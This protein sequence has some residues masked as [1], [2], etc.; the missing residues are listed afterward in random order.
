MALNITGAKY[1]IQALNA[2]GTTTATIATGTFV[3]G[4]FSLTSQR[5]AS[6]FTS[7]GVFKGIAWVRRFISTT[8]VELENQFVDPC[9]GLFATQLVGDQIL[10]SKNFSESAGIGFAVDATAL[11]VA[12]TGHITFGTLG[13]ETSVCVYDERYD[14]AS[15]DAF[16]PVGGVTVLG[17]LISYDGTG[18]ASL[19]WSRDCSIKPRS[20][21]A[22]GGAGSVA[23][24]V[25][26]T[27][28]TSAH[29]FM[30]G[31]GVSGTFQS[32]DF[33]GAQGSGATNKSFAFFGTRLNYP[34][35]SP[36]NGGS[37]ASNPS[38]HVLYKTIH[39][40]A[41]SNADLIM[42]GNGIA[43]PSFLSFTQSGAG[44][45]LGIFRA[46]SVANFGSPAGQRTIVNDLGTGALIDG[47]GGG[48]Y[49]FVNVITPAVSMTRRNS[50]IPIQLSF[51]DD[52]TNLQIGST[53]VVRRT[54]DNVVAASV[55]G[56]AS[57]TFTAS[58][59]QSTYSATVNGVLTPL[60]DFTSYDYG[61]KDYGYGV[62]SGNHTV[63]NYPLGTGGTGRNLSLGGLINQLSDADVTLSQSA[64]L[65]LSSKINI[66]AGTSTVSVTSGSVT[67]DELYD[68]AVAH[69]VSSVANAQVPSLSAYLFTRSGTSAAL[70]AGWSIAVDSGATL[71]KGTK[72]LGVTSN[73]ALTGTLTNI[74]ITGNV[75][76]ATPTNLTGVTVTGTLTYNTNSATSI[77]YTTCTIGT[78]AN[79]GVG[80]V[81]ITPTGSTVTTYTDAEI[82]Y[83]D[84]NLTATGITSATIYPS[85]A[86]RDANTNAGPV[87]TTVLNFKLGS[88]VSGVVM[89]G[90]VYLRVNFSGTILFSSI[91]L[92]LGTNEL[93]LGVQG[94]LSTISSTL[95]IVGKKAALAAA[96]SA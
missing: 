48:D 5:M 95:T 20:D 22:G 32:S 45:P 68:Y 63:V 90:T 28:G 43:E 37:W 31:G 73:V 16:Q 61:I 85:A 12:L 94:Q 27:G 74:T 33:I 6:L 51:S 15:T 87:F 65:A 53:V 29:F 9:T 26:P 77:T 91:A 18:R 35:T 66:N 59:L 11:T 44:S 54:V 2:V 42:W 25:L 70:A 62:V 96:L 92:A 23:Y 3:S 52:Y 58:V 14:I 81:T 88:T 13:S 75:T 57:S 21:Y 30:F 67:V 46:P 86:D 10:I 89:T 56:S 69:S 19:K 34:A 71:T 47:V 17:K 41:F 84:S 39:E 49:R 60:T 79:S 93:D 7:A 24:C 76:Q 1:A 4:D 50:N 64:A 40:A 36:S 82:N 55:V 78:V 83:L 8:Q 72:F 80:L 38:R